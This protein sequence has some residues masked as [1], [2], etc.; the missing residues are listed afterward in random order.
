MRRDF[1]VEFLVA[2][3]KTSN[4]LKK[5]EKERNNKTM[6][7]FLTIRIVNNFRTRSE[8]FLSV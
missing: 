1:I 6:V 7:A 2:L 5:R 3:L 4:H 8:Y